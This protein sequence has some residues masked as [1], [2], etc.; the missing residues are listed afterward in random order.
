M[1]MMAVIEMVQVELQVALLVVLQVA[2]VKLVSH[3]NLILLPMEVNAV[4]LPG[5]NLE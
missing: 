2:E 5:Q 1:I 4:I 3:V